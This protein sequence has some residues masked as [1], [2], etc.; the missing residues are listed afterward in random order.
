VTQLDILTLAPEEQ[1]PD[2]FEPDEPQAPEKPDLSRARSFLTDLR[3]SG[4]GE[5]LVTD[6][7]L[8]PAL[9]SLAKDEPPLDRQQIWK[10]RQEWRD[11]NLLRERPAASYDARTEEYWGQVK[12]ALA[13]APE[14]IVDPYTHLVASFA[15]ADHARMGDYT[16]DARE[17][18]REGEARLSLGR[19]QLAIGRLK[20][21]RA[22]FRA[23]AKAEPFLP[24]V[25][26]HLGVASLF[27]RADSE[28]AD[29]FQ[30]ALDQAPGDLRAEAALGVTRY[31]QRKYPEAE[32]RFRRTAGP[33]GLRAACRSLLACSLRMQGKWD[34][35][36]VE[37]GFLRG[38]GSA[39]WSS[40]A[41]Q[42]LDCVA[43]GEEQGAPI[44]T[45]RRAREIAK[46]LVTAGGPAAALVYLFLENYGQK[47]LEKD[48]RWWLAVPV[49]V[50]G[51]LLAKW[52]GRFTHRAQARE[53][54]NC[55][56]G[57]PCWQATTWMQPRRSE[58]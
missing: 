40:V 45:P 38:S 54:G 11:L 14:A 50:G 19:A 1:A 5:L 6:A 4:F 37:L 43:R 30:R 49:T 2:E 18:G 47:L 29:A 52:L 58:F 22:T 20:S 32:E 41:Q 57:L 34:E 17:Y 27:A 7:W 39:R 23:A 3:P 31:H 13:R 36:R 48:A 26:W 21:A 53:F 12:E 9:S 55:E 35:A 56:Q 15:D 42:C 25:W 24:G 28:A 33:N 44:A 51:A 46:Q 10:Q 8:P 16:R